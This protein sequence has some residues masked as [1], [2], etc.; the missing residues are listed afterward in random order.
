MHIGSRAEGEIPEWTE[1]EIV[2]TMPIDPLQQPHDKPHPEGHNV[3]AEQA[4]AQEHPKGIDQGVFESVGVLHSPA[5][6]M[7]VLVVH[8]V[9]VLVEEGG[10]EGSVHPVEI[11]VLYQQE[12]WELEQNFKPEGISSGKG[13]STPQK[14][15]LN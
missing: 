14:H 2:A 5:V 13:S 11:K 1:P 8:L 10:V 12:Q 9:H 4:G 3:R 15:P 7:L 6:W